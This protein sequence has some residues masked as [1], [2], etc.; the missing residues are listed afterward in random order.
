MAKAIVAISDF[1]PISLRRLGAEFQTYSNWNWIWQWINSNYNWL[2][3]IKCLFW[4]KTPVSQFSNL[5]PHT[6]WHAT[7]AQWK[8]FFLSGAAAIIHRDF[9]CQFIFFFNQIFFCIKWTFFISQ[10]SV[11]INLIHPFSHQLQIHGAVLNVEP[12]DCLEMS[13]SKFWKIILI[14]QLWP[15]SLFLI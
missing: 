11:S 15:K 12:I 7:S 6:N 4:P 14:I 8:C 10:H 1:T 9:L 13:C 2:H 3:D 5:A